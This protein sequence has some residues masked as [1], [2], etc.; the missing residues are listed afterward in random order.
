VLPLNSYCHLYYCLGGI[1]FCVCFLLQVIKKNREERKE[2]K[3]E[4][5]KEEI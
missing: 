1:S 4:R 3:K 2:R 5:K